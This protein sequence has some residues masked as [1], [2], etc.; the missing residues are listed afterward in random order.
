MHSTTQATRP[1]EKYVRRCS[2]SRTYTDQSR[3]VVSSAIADYLC[4]VAL[5]FH[6]NPNPTKS[7]LP[8]HVS[9]DTVNG[10]GVL[11]VADWKIQVFGDMHNYNT[12]RSVGWPQ[13]PTEQSS[14]VCSIAI[15]TIMG[16]SDTPK[17]CTGVVSTLPPIGAP[18]PM[19]LPYAL[20][21]AQTNT[22]HEDAPSVLLDSTDR[23]VQLPSA[24]VTVI[25][26]RP[27]SAVAR[28]PHF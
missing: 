13:V 25:L 4:F 22:R 2:Q 11:P 24:T 10:H 15:S 18:N 21:Q 23:Q 8:C 14:R 3:S 27:G 12:H 17:N 9:L 19:L 6:P 1:F 7:A 16:I 26:R 20:I 5:V 28:S